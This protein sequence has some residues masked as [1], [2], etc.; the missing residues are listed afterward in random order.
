MLLQRVTVQIGAEQDEFFAVGF[1]KLWQK[2]SGIVGE[3]VANGQQPDCAARGLICR[4]GC[5]G[6]R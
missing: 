5:V 4:A 6:K 1:G 2:M 3:A